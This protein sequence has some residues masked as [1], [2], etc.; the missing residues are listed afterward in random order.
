MGQTSLLNTIK[1]LGEGKVTTPIDGIRAGLQGCAGGEKAINAENG[2]LE[3]YVLG[4]F[5]F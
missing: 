5:N 4:L 2:C 1:Q 3:E